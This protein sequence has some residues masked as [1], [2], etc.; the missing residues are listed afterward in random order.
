MSTRRST[1]MPAVDAQHDFL[2]ARRR[3][4]VASL[5]ARLRREPDDINVILP[6]EEVIKALGFVS[7][8]SIGL[9]V[10]PLDAI[11][12]TIDRQR[13]FD[14]QFRPTSR[15]MRS[16]WEQIAAAMRRGE[17]LPPVDLL[18][19][20]EIYFVRDG[21]HRV[22]VASALGLGD[23][24]AYVTDVITRVD[25]SIAIKFTD[26]PVKSHERVF[27]ERVPLP[28]E[29]H[30]EISVADPWD[31]ATLAEGIEAWGFRAMQEHGELFDRVQTAQLWLEHEYRPVVSMLR[32]AGLIRDSTETE[33]YM[34]IAAERYRLL[35]TH[36]WN[37]D[38][39]ARVL[40]GR[41]RR[42]HLRS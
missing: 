7:E 6:Y 24:D 33:A 21:H 26:L 16:R 1:G 38:V 14:R 4:T 9:Q 42:H 34:R 25:A 20:G 30:G 32:E 12:G 36:A 22:S 37:D 29:A 23:I 41:R 31:Y 27:F 17:S 19:V 8:R 11:V 40:E 13:D 3:A 35:R 10:V 28:P 5:V 15:R 2:R 39:L 18:K